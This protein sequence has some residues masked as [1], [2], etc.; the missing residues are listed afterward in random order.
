V[1]D[2]RR[3]TARGHR[4]P[5]VV[6]AAT[7]DEHRRAIKMRLLNDGVEIIEQKSAAKA[8]RSVR[9]D[10]PELVLCDLDADPAAGFELLRE[11]RE[12]PVLAAVPLAF[13][14]DH[15]DR[16][17]KLRALREGA[18]DF[19][20]KSGDLENLAL[21]DIVQ[22]LASGMKTAC[23]S[24]ESR[25]RRGQIWFENGAARHAHAAGIDGE[26]AFFE[27]VRWS[28]GSFVIE[29]GVSTKQQSVTQDALFLVMEGMRLLDED[30]ERSATGASGA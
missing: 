2:Q 19:L 15:A 26:P 17:L 25:G 1:L 14:A 21:A 13:L 4:K 28:E 20:C 8:L 22:M 23:V 3:S 9:K 24:L 30:E 6:L 27:M 16:I 10:T 5:T 11:M 18:D 12:D 29:H 7:Q